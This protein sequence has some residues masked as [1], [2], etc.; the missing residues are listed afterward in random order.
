MKD[1]SR[2]GVNIRGVTGIRQVCQGVSARRLANVC[3]EDGDD[4][5]DGSLQI[6]LTFRR[7]TRQDL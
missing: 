3:A 2:V 4:G 6:F 1:H 7:Q 5:R